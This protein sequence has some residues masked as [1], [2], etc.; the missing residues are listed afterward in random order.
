MKMQILSKKENFLNTISEESLFETVQHINSFSDANADV[1]VI[2]DTHIPYSELSSFDFS[3]I[4]H[5]FYVLQTSYHTGFEK[6]V[7]AICDSRDICMIPPRLTEIQI[8]EFILKCIEPEKQVVKNVV[9]FFSSISNVGTT[10]TCFS[11]AKAISR[12]SK[13]KV[14]VLNCNAWDSGTEFMNYKGKYLDEIKNRLSGRLIDSESEFLSFF[15]MIEEDSLYILAG[16]RNT[17]MERLFKKEE[18]HYLIQKAKETFDIVL[19]DAGSHFDNAN[20]VQSLTESDLRFFVNDQQP[21]AIRKF[22]QFFS[23]LLYPLGYKRDDFLMILNKFEDKSHYPS[24]KEIHSELTIPVITTI[25][26]SNNGLLSEIESKFLYEYEDIA[27]QESIHLIAKSVCSRVN[28]DFMPNGSEKK[29]K[30]FFGM[31]V[32]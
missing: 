17:K 31:V 19:I 9:C 28:Y 2:D 18:I 11:V 1:L 15:Q 25:L 7:K 26:Q 23:D 30:K 27:Y 3:S 6:T 21:K 5:V 32:G 20:M 10:S 16:N 8:K 22:N 24:A 13:A 29:K 12:F 14:G 4:E